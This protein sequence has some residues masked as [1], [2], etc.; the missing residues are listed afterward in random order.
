MVISVLVIT[1]VSS[2][3]FSALAAGPISCDRTGTMTVTCCQDHIVNRS[4]ANPA[5]LVRYCT[6]CTVGP[7][8]YTG[9][10]DNPFGNLSD[11]GERYIDMSAEQPPTPS[12]PTLPIAGENIVPGDTGVL[13]DPP[14]PP[15][16]GPAAPLQGGVLEQQQT[17]PPFAPGSSP[18]VLEQLEQSEGVSPGFLERQQQPPSDQG[19]SRIATTSN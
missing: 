19:G 15:S 1:Y 9:T 4:P 6:D 16:S 11:C 13:E 7:G 14:T 5:G 3:T 18:G 10:V 8:G 2:A 17:P 12:L